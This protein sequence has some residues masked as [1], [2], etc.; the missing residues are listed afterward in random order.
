MPQLRV[1]G[2]Y[3]QSKPHRVLQVVVE[4][5]SMDPVQGADS[6]SLRLLVIY[7]RKQTSCRF[8]TETCSNCE[9]SH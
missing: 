5:R 7:Q 4:L 2:Y 9:T 6:T 3:V 8:V 1:D